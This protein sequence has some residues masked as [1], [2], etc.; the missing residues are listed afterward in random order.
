[1]DVL[2]QYG[3]TGKVMDWTVVAKEELQEEEMC[4]VV[5]AQSVDKFV[6]REPDSHRF[7]SALAYPIL[8]SENAHE[9]WLLPSVKLSPKEMYAPPFWLMKRESHAEFAN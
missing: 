3:A 4:V 7:P 8:A 5:A 1:M 2:L 6:E 9:Q